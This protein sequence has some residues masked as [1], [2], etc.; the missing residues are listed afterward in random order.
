MHWIHGRGGG[1][2]GADV[3]RVMRSV[4]CTKSAFWLLC[5]ESQGGS[6]K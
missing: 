3:A 6:E 2:Q 1:D 5:A 4:P